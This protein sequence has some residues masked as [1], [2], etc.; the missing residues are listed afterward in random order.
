MAWRNRSVAALD[1]DDLI[2]TVLDAID[3]LQIADETWVIFTSDNGYHLGEHQL[4]FG[5][6]HPYNTDVN[7]PLYIR[8]PGTC[9]L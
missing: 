8:G 7:L 9:V 2:G 4:D 5:K 1:L 6:E 3:E